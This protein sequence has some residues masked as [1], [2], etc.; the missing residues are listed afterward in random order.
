M[1]TTEANRSGLALTAIKHNRTGLSDI[2]SDSNSASLSVPKS[3]GGNSAPRDVLK[4][5]TFYAEKTN[6][7][8]PKKAENDKTPKTSFNSSSNTLLI[9]ETLTET[10]LEATQN[11]PT[12]NS[13]R[14]ESVDQHL[15]V[16]QNQR[17]TL[18][19]ADAAGKAGPLY[20]QF[21]WIGEF[22]PPEGF[23]PRVTHYAYNFCKH[24]DPTPEYDNLIDNDDTF[25]AQLQFERL[26]AVYM[27]SFK[28]SKRNIELKRLKK[29]SY[30]HVLYFLEEKYCELANIIR[31]RL[32][33]KIYETASNEQIMKLFW[34]TYATAYQSL[35]K[36]LDYEI[37]NIKEYEEHYDE[38]ST[39]DTKEFYKAKIDDCLRQKI[40]I[41]LS[42]EILSRDLVH[43]T[44][45]KKFKIF[46]F[47]YCPFLYSRLDTFENVDLITDPMDRDFQQNLVS[48]FLHSLQIDIGVNDTV[49]PYP[50]ETKKTSSQIVVFTLEVPFGLQQFTNLKAAVLNHCSHMKVQPTFDL[51]PPDY[52]LGGDQYTKPRTDT[53]RGIMHLHSNEV[54]LRSHVTPQSE[55]IFTIVSRL[56]HC[57]NCGALEHSRFTCPKQSCGICHK[58]GHIGSACP[59]NYRNH[60]QVNFRKR[61]SKLNTAPTENYFSSETISEQTL[62]T[63]LSSAYPDGFQILLSSAKGTETKQSNILS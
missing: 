46:D 20:Q 7:N 40:N 14:F 34:S 54:P 62:T 10:T 11:P 3:N 47:E 42:L 24:S 19:Y 38:A 30:D 22:T 16:T 39:S 6:E 31:F 36:D 50:L 37:E 61:P 48:S 17:Q 2:N 1:S 12:T 28:Y 5:P 25:G 4:S 8:L 58:R 33:S 27:F 63:P 57:A 26:L 41:E 15:I 43:L 52:K 51:F 35:S 9:A 44:M 56:H 13:V 55:T 23:H 32:P 60:T 21:P 45:S 49:C 53:I 29:S 59:E 18:S